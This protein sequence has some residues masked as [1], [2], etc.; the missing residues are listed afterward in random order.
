MIYGRHEFCPFNRG[1]SSHIFR[2]NLLLQ[3][4][5]FANFLIG[6][7]FPQIWLCSQNFL[8]YEG[9]FLQFFYHCKVQTVILFLKI[10][11]V[12]YRNLKNIVIV[13]SIYKLYSQNAITFA[14]LKETPKRR[15]TVMS[16]L[17]KISTDHL[18]KYGGGEE[19]LLRRPP[20]PLL[21]QSFEQLFK[22]DV[23]GFSSTSA[24][25][26]FMICSHR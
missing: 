24:Y 22:D 21:Q 11:N 3:C 10:C 13:H 12:Y 6:K 25:S 4:Y 16:S 8:I 15:I 17:N 26:C 9:N 7:T 2:N 5:I 23:N 14:T 18:G 1:M 19:V 20:P